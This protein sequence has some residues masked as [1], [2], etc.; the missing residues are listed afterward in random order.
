MRLVARVPGIEI[1]KQQ[2]A[3]IGV[4]GVGTSLVTARG[5]PRPTT[6]YAPLCSMHSTSSCAPSWWRMVAERWIWHQA[7]DSAALDEMH[8]AGAQ[9]LRS[10]ALDQGYERGQGASVAVPR[11]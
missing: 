8:G 9:I 11:I 3:R 7:T 4:W 5:D 2:G 6:A 10:D 1:L